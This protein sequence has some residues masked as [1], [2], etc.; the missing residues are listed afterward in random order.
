[1]NQLRFLSLLLAFCGLLFFSACEDD[2][3]P[4]NE[5]ELITTVKLTFTKSG[6]TPIVAQWKDLDGPGGNNPV[7]TPAT[8]TL[9][10]NSTYAVAVEMLDET[11]SPAEDITEEIE[12]EDDEHQLFF[13]RSTNLN[14]AIAYGD[15]DK[16]GKP[17]G[18]SNTFT[19]GA[20]STGTLTVILLHEL[21]K[22]ATGVTQG[23]P[24]NAGG[25]TDI[26]TT[27]PFSITIQ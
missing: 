22:S 25:E 6:S 15:T 14:L 13:G 17:I 11:K 12:E 9:A 27:P 1:M 3:E 4:V 16:N 7:L 19:T 24:A 8:V 21:D 2:P 20:A 18:L 26:E 10:A 23:N 5:E